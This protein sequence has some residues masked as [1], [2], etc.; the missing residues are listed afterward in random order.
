MIQKGEVYEY[1]RVTP[2]DH[3]DNDDFFDY[4]AH[5]SCDEI[6]ETVNHEVDGM[7]P[8]D[9]GEWEEMKEMYYEYCEN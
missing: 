4:K 1:V 3:Q 6:W 7:L 8:R 2:W 5:V 9:A